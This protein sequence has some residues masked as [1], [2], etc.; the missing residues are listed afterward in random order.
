LDGKAICASKL[1]SLADNCVLRDDDPDIEVGVRSE[2]VDN[3]VAVVS[4]ADG[5]VPFDTGRT[6]RPA[7]LTGES[8]EPDGVV[9]V[10]VV[11]EPS[12]AGRS[13]VGV[14]GYLVIVV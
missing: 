1:D 5:D 3:G 11:S 13:G 8:A 4:A 6:G 2:L 12:V 10:G 9:T 14:G 7:A